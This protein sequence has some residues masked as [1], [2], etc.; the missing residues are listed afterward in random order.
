MES[1]DY[2]IKVVQKKSPAYLVLKNLVANNYREHY[3]AI[4]EVN[5]DQFIALCS[6]ENEWLACFGANFSHARKLFSEI[7]LDGPV[8]YIL[9]PIVERS[10]ERG[11]I[12]ECGSFASLSPG[13]GKTLL[14]S[15]SWVLWCEGVH[16]GLVTVTPIVRQL[17]K[18]LDMPFLPI[19]AT[20]IGRLSASAIE[21]WG[22]YYSTEPVTGVLDIKQGL[23]NS[24]E[25]HSGNYK[26]R[27]LNVVD[28]KKNRSRAA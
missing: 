7:Y 19:C 13:A 18:R 14:S 15:L 11:V 2:Q 4:V 22:S 23:L 27:E 20:D 5:P 12:A 8:E 9:E 24:L 26:I 21:Q 25:T 28:R 3:G 17:F 1:H 10:V 6:S 16:Y